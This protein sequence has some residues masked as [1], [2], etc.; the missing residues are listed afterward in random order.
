MTDSGTSIRTESL[1]GLHW[2]AIGLALVTG[3][4]HLVL[5]VSFVS[6]PMGWSFLFAG[7]V[8]FA[9]IVAVL[10]D[11]RRRLIYLLG[12]PFTGGQIVAWYLVN[13]PDFSPLGI[14]DKVVQVVLIVV[15]ALLYT[16][17][18]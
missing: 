9:A 14:G 10:Y 11:Y 15:L 5:G 18:S 1:T 12:I 4:I 2:L 7:V 16:R 6:D 13:A 17:E 8:F 3:V